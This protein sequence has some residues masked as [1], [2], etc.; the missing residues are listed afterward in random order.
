MVRTQCTYA[1]SRHSISEGV[2]AKSKIDLTEITHVTKISMHVYII[3]L[4]AL[5]VFKKTK[6]EKKTEFN[7]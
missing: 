3:Y 7:I 6:I 4:L 1:T 2:N 5:S